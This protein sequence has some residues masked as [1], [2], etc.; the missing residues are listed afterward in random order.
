MAVQQYKRL[1]A[2]LDMLVT[3]AYYVVSVS[4][5]CPGAEPQSGRER[6]SEM[7]GISANDPTSIVVG[8]TASQ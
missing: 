2:R 8:H 1:L 5:P 3:A 7:A 6:N 4:A